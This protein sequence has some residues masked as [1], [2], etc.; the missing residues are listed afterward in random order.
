MKEVVPW[1]ILEAKINKRPERERLFR[2]ERALVFDFLAHKRRKE[3]TIIVWEDDPDD[4][5]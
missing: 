3:Q 2:K 4:A 1:E 5:A